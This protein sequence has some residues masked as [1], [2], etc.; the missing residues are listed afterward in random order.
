MEQAQ[1]LGQWFGDQCSLV[2][3]ALPFAL[4]MERNGHDHVSG[5]LFRFAMDNLD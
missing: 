4:S 1:A 3:P 2:V 5:E